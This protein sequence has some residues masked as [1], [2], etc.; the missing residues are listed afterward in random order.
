MRR[1]ASDGLLDA[2][3]TPER[4]VQNGTSLTVSPSSRFSVWRRDHGL[5]TSYSW[6]DASNDAAPGLYQYRTTF[7]TR[8]HAWRPT[9]MSDLVLLPDV[10]TGKWMDEAR[11]NRR[12]HLKHNQ[13]KRLLFT[14][15][16]LDLPHLIKRS[17]VLRTGLQPTKRPLGSQADEYYVYENVGPTAASRVAELLDQDLQD[18]TDGECA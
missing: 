8:V 17:L 5:R 11:E 3:P 14:P 10:T 1:K 16:A 7:G 4:I 13:G 2:L 18:S 15:V 9:L 12:T 6:R